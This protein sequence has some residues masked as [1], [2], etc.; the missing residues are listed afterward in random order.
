MVGLVAFWLYLVYIIS[1]FLHLTARVPA[2][3][4]VRFDLF[5]VVVIAVLAVAQ[6]RVSDSPTR[7]SA[8][9]WALFALTAYCLVTLPLVQWPGSVI[10]FG[11]E[12]YIKAVVFF[13]F[14]VRLVT[15]ERRLRWLLLV[16]VLCQ[17]FRILEPVYLHLTTGYW[18]SFASMADWE[19]MNRLSGAPYDVVNPNGL[20]FVVLTVICF[21]HYLWTGNRVGRLAYALLLP[22]S[23]YA[24]VLTGSRSGMI[25]LGVVFIAVWIKSR[26]KVLLGVLAVA[27][28]AWS[29]PRLSGD[30]ADRYMSIVDS[31]TKNAATAQGRLEGVRTSFGVALRRPLFGYGL[32]TSR[33]ALANFAGSDQPA[34]DLYAEVSIELGFLGLG[35]FMAFLWSVATQIWTHGREWREAGVSPPV[36]WT[37]DALQVFMILN[38]VFGLA[39]YGLTSYEWY[40]L[41]GLVAVVIR[42]ADES[43]RRVPPS[44]LVVGNQAVISS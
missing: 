8:T 6:G 38:L 2:L 3:G 23:L 21:A 5:L 34:H 41:A 11:F 7:R 24:L 35:V 27:I 1:W 17:S 15:T 40:F 26:R 29:L 16:F 31:A 42:L 28:V 44:S 32:G 30:L 9:S 10:R 43:R 37:G 33:E 4:A 36:V 19:T 14:T 39:S 20:A 12:A 25:G 22:I 13:F 18:G